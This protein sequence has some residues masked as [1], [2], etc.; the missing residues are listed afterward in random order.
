MKKLLIFLSFFPILSYTQQLLPKSK[1]ELVKHN[2]YTLSYN[3]SHEQANWVH[4]KLNSSFLSGKTKRN[5][6]FRSD[7]YVSSKSA[8]PNDYK[9]SGYDRGHLAPAGDM[10][11]SSLSMQESFYMSNMSPQHPS[12][13]RGGW[14]KLE[15]LVRAWGEN[16]EIY[17]S[18]AGV[19][20]SNNLGSIG[21]N[22]ITVPAEFYKIIYAPSKQIM[23]GFL[24]PNMS[25]TK[26]LI[27]YVVSVDKIE[28]LTGID[29]YSQ[30]PDEME[31]KLEST[32]SLRDWNFKL[33]P[34]TSSKS[35]SKSETVQCNG[36]AKTTGLRCRNKTKNTNNYCYVHQDQS[37]NYTKPDKS[38][39]VGK[40]SAFTQKGTRC[41]RKASRGSEYCW[42]HAK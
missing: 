37:K 22:S 27:S 28:A 35:S 36:K 3:E 17:V 19:L 34:T 4:Y 13:N 21:I 1:G 23:I 30:L 39:Y 16:F 26:D 24:M 41:K 10:K 40:C 32:I 5:D 2:F 14:K 38:N 7:P 11:Y 8:G 20:D 29:F 42:Q 9:G 18:T 12:F 6:K 15:S 25:I 31:N 33:R